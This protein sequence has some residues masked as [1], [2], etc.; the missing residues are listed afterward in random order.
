MDKNVTS[1]LIVILLAGGLVFYLNKIPAAEKSSSAR[2]E[3]RET[4]VHVVSGSVVGFMNKEK[5]GQYLT[6]TKG[7]T[8]YVFANDKKLESN[9]VGDCLKNWPA[10]VY[11][12][13]DLQSSTDTLSKRMNIIK[14]SDGTY[15]YAYGQEP[16]YYYKEDK[17][18]GET[19]GN[20]LSDGKWNTVMVIN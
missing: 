1:A 4:G 12:N 15:Q 13:K 2:V 16:L 10:F 7:M 11:D 8:L 9:C 18:P 14:R 17:N 5:L 6:D 3:N 20:G 19:N